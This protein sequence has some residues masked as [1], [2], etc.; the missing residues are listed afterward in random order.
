MKYTLGLDI[1]IASLGWA[2]YSNESN[3]LIDSGVRIFDV[4]ENP[5]DKSPLSSVRRDA[6]SSR[7]RFR[8]TR[9]RMQKIRELMLKSNFITQKELDNLFCQKSQNGKELYN[10]HVPK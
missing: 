9:Y 4:G 6:R 3:N 5:K 1:G 8:R 10:R 7:R 2:I